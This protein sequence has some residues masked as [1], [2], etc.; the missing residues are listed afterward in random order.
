M[1]VTWS[2]LK[3]ATALVLKAATWVLVIAVMASALKLL[4]WVAVRPPAAVPMR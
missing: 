3:A 1:A 2:V 4:I